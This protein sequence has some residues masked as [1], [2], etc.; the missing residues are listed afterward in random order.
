[1]VIPPFRLLFIVHVGGTHITFLTKRNLPLSRGGSCPVKCLI[2]KH[3]HHFRVWK[4]TNRTITK[5]TAR[6][7][8]YGISRGSSVARTSTLMAPATKPTMTRSMSLLCSGI[9]HA[10]V[11]LVLEIPRPAP[12]AAL[13]LRNCPMRRSSLRRI[14][15]TAQQM[16]APLPSVCCFAML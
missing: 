2:Y 8:R 4:S 11:Y 10:P 3:V 9:R 7:T 16:T 6:I 15:R 13:R 12:V 14:T 1:M 5:M